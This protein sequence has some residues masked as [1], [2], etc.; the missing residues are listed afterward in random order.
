MAAQ[1][2]AAVFNDVLNI[3]S[4]HLAVSKA[5]GAG[6][7][8]MGTRQIEESCVLGLACTAGL[9]GIDHATAH[10]CIIR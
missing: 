1:S 3:S 10:I 8:I 7:M 4:C 2:H 9:C 6:F 5:S